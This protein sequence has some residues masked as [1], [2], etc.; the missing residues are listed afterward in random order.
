M[1][2]AITQALGGALFEEMT[3]SDVRPAHGWH[4]HGLSVPDHARSRCFPLTSDHVETPSPLT[5]LGAKGCGEGSSMSLPV[6]IANAVADAL[7][8]DGVAINSLP[9]HGNVLHQTAPPKGD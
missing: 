9:L 2:G 7:A 5:R 1:H 8:P 3:Y 4:V 6:A